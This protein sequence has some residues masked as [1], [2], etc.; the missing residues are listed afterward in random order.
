LSSK[1]I[2]L[3][4]RG[5]QIAADYLRAKGY[6][7]EDRNYRQKTGEIDI[8]CRDGN[9]FVFVEVK[10]R[11]HCGFGHPTEAVTRRKQTQISRTALLYLNSQELFDTPTR[12]DVVGIILAET[13]PEISHIIGAFEAE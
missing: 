6:R 9:T 2:S 3:G 10:T 1:R 11:Q 7:I 12:F 5:E 13:G 8:I 4:K